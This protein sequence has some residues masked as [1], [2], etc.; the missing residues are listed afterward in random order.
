MS[1]D[2]N[3]YD[4]GSDDDVDGGSGPG[5]GYAAG[6]GD[7]DPYGHI[8]DPDATAGASAGAGA[9]PTLPGGGPLQPSPTFAPAVN[10]PGLSGVA[11]DLPALPYPRPGGG[12]S[13]SAPPTLAPSVNVPGLLRAPPDFPALSDSGPGLLRDPD[14]LAPSVNV[15]GLLTAPPDLP[16][17][18]YGGSGYGGLFPGKP[19]VGAV[20]SAARPGVSKPAAK[21]APAVG[22]PL[23]QTT[24]TNFD[25]QHKALDDY[26]AQPG[27]EGRRTR[28]RNGRQEQ[29]VYEDSR[30]ILTGGVGHKI[31][32]QD[33]LKNQDTVPDDLAN[34]WLAKDSAAALGAAYRQAAE[35]GI[36]DPR[37]LVPLASVNFQLGTGWNDKFP[38]TWR[39]MVT[40]DYAGAAA[41]AAKSHWNAQSPTRV[42]AFQD[43]LRALP[44]KGRS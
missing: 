30:H 43:A 36:K 37:F 44:P 5:P 7:A 6:Y 21:R 12:G 41:E 18:S 33:H 25:D 15:P 24:S 23:P 13:F 27:V 28:T 4:D 8:A 17:L 2:Q 22:P 1:E 19:G 20:A 31:L 29:Y 34:R 40:G 39:K 32:P 9:G 10:A 42:K 3:V 35:A 26:L 38:E 16:P 11:P 14:A